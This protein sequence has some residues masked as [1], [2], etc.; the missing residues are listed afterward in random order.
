MNK[1]SAIINRCS[2]KTPHTMEK[3]RYLLALR[4]GDFDDEGE[5]IKISVKGLS[6]IMS[7]A[8]II[9]KLIVKNNIS[10]NEVAICYYSNFDLAKNSADKLKKFLGFG[11]VIPD[12]GPPLNENEKDIAVATAKYLLQMSEG[13]DLV[14]Y[15]TTSYGLRLV[16]QAIFK[17][18]KW[19]SIPTDSIFG[20][21]YVKN[22]FGFKVGLS[23]VPPFVYIE[24]IFI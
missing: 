4:N 1:K 8:E 10:R 3:Q 22:K 18:K 14:I 19:N 12:N 20:T 2:L 16:P 13:K 21:N 23:S 24:E 9:R 7:V 11:K 15:F 5:T 17:M 6:Q